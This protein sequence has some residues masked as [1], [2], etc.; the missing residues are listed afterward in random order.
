MIKHIVRYNGGR[1]ITLNKR[2]INAT[3]ETT[4]LILSA[5]P[6][7]SSSWYR[8][9]KI[10]IDEIPSLKPVLDRII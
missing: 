1:Q 9:D 8:N 7:N 2:G 4:T 5:N 3:I 10:E 6:L